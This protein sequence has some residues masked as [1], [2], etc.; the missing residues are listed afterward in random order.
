MNIL[1]L[2]HLCVC[3]CVWA[4]LCVWSDA[5]YLRHH[6]ETVTL[7]TISADPLLQA[8]RRVRAAGLDCSLI[9]MVRWRAG[10]AMCHVECQ[11]IVQHGLIMR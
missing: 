10:S 6:T 1:K 2:E 3:K 11:W 9:Q 5:G 4:R 8:P 7:L